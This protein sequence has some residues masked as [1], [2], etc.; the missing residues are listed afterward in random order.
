MFVIGSPRSGTSVLP[1]S[2][3]HHWDFWT[4]DETEF[5]FHLFARA[6]EVHQ[7]LSERKGTFIT[8]QDVDRA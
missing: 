5:I 6:G 1:W 3:A 7:A 2:L 8:Q 4:S